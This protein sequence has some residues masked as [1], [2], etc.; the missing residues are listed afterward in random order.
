[1]AERPVVQLVQEHGEPPLGLRL[2]PT[3]LGPALCKSCWT[4]HRPAEPCG[5][6][7]DEAA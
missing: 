2:K 6:G 5:S 7:E 4:F 3:A 1:M